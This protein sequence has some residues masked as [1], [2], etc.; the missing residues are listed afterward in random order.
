MYNEILELKIG[1]LNDLKSQ[2]SKFEAYNSITESDKE[3][4]VFCKNVEKII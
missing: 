2:I 4:N 1:F 3:K